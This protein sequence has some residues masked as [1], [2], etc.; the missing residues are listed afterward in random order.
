MGLPLKGVSMFELQ[1]LVSSSQIWLFKSED[2]VMLPIQSIL[3]R[4]E[5]R[6]PRQLEI[7]LLT[8]FT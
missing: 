1:A 7:L 5:D 3:K 6:T 4:N 8:C 2:S